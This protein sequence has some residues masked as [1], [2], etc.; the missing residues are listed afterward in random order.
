M[1]KNCW[2]FMS[3]GREPNGKNQHDLGV[4]PAA[5]DSRLHGIH[6]GYNSGR[7]CWVLTGTFC[8]GS[9]QGT[10]AKKFHTCAACDFYQAVRKEESP[11]FVLTPILLKKINEF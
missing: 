6:E 5:V 10:F 1:K 11:K 9:V 3:C 7:A 4:C 8:K 2:E